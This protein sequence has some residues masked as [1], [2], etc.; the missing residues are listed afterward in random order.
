MIATNVNDQHI[1]FENKFNRRNPKMT[2]CIKRLT[3]VIVMASVAVTTSLVTSAE[4]Y[5]NDPIAILAERT[6]QRKG[7][8]TFPVGSATAT[9][10]LTKGWSSASASTSIDKQSCAVSVSLVG[11]YTDNGIKKTTGGG[12]SNGSSGVSAGC[13]TPDGQK[14][15][16]VTSTHQA[17]Y[18]GHTGKTTLTE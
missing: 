2:R 6:V 7:S 17:S 11:I 15:S 8:N 12:N 3:A 1:M 4:V 18:D 13:S 9:A 10:T 5:T 16:S 14:L